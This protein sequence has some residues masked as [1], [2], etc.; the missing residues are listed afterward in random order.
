M[1]LQHGPA[2]SADP[3]GSRETGHT[4]RRF[5]SPSIVRCPHEGPAAQA[6]AHLARPLREHLRLRRVRPGRSAFDDHPGQLFRL[7]HALDRSMPSL[8][9]TADW[10]PDWWAGGYP[11]LQFYPPGFAL[12]GAAVRALLLWRP[13][14][15]RS[16]ASWC[17]VVFLAPGLTTYALLVRVWSAAGGSCCLAPSSR[18]PAPRTSE[19][20]EAGL[21]WGTAD[22]PPR[23]RLRCPSSLWPCVRGSR[24]A[25][26]PVRAPP[27]PP[28]QSCPI[29][30]RCRRWPPLLGLATALALLG[31][32]R[33]GARSGK[34]ARP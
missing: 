3:P 10:N 27:W 30:P 14:V 20:V 4:E 32:A 25:N 26:F 22:N 33:G 28:W 13:S 15:E 21:R 5:P 19:E 6:P 23:P 16:I 31:Q 12:L 8:L 11:E 17:A 29:P 24:A 2:R 7:W 18:S 9:W 1:P 34:P